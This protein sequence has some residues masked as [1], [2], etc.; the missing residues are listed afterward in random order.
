MHR[1][2]GTLRL[3]RL[4]LLG[5]LR[6]RLRRRGRGG[7]RAGRNH[8]VGRSGLARLL[9]GL[10]LHGARRALVYG[11]VRI[12]LCRANASSAGLR[13]V[14]FMCFTRFQRAYSS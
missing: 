12:A 14:D 4:R 3:R 9:R 7:A 2:I 10:R 1:V 5:H 13:R 8:E 6:L 11:N